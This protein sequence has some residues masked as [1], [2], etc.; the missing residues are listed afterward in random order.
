MLLWKLGDYPKSL[1][2]LKEAR[3]VYE[4]DGGLQSEIL[5]E[6]YS[7]LGKVAFSTGNLYQAKRY[8]VKALR[9]IEFDC[10]LEGESQHIQLLQAKVLRLLG[11]V[12][13]AVGG[14]TDKMANAI[15]EALRVQHRI[16]GCWHGD[17]AST[18][19]TLGQLHE[20]QGAFASAA[21]IYLDALDIYRSQEH[22]PQEHRP[23]GGSAATATTTSTTTNSS[24]NHGNA[25][26]CRVD[27][28]IWVL[29]CHE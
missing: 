4:Q 20:A 22:R 11:N 15:M 3:D 10:L 17:Y 1:K 14:N 24:S 7:A 28:L 19:L 13:L 29:H 6:I 23:Q 18:L 26:S 2:R 21:G 5:V 27:V 16:T 9:T 25:S 12:L 8:Y